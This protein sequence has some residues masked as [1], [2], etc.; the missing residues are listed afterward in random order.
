MSIFVNQSQLTP[1]TVNRRQLP[2]GDCGGDLIFDLREG[3]DLIFKQHLF[4]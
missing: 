4:E 2:F 3:G 1:I